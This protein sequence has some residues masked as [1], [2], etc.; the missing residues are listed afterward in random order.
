MKPKTENTGTFSK[1]KLCRKAAFLCIIL[2]VIL[3]F[4]ACEVHEGM[5]IEGAVIGGNDRSEDTKVKVEEFEF[6]VKDF[7]NGYRSE[8]LFSCKNNSK[9]TVEWVQV[10]LKPKKLDGLAFGKYLAENKDSE[11]AAV[12]YRDLS[13]EEIIARLQKRM[14]DQ[15]Y[16]RCIIY[17]EIPPGEISK[18]NRIYA[19][20]YEEL[21]DIS[22]RENLD[23]VAL[24]FRYTDEKGEE[25][26][27]IYDYKSG[28]YRVS[29]H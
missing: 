29:K 21:K 18:E 7:N 28:R 2:I 3:A 8:M 14:E 22:Q 15:Y 13:D 25:H 20:G 1:L 16:Y 12:W 26:K 6:K 17:D 11:A 23:L 9:Y 4:S 10:T 19:N 27:V 24:S 5:G